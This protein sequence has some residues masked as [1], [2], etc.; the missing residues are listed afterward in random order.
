[1]TR[2]RLDHVGITVPDLDAATGFFVRCFGATEL[3]RLPDSGENGAARRLGVTE[4]SSFALVMLEVGGNRLELLAWRPQ[5][6]GAIPAA[7]DP[8]GAHV[9]I[10]VEDLD[11]TLRVLAGEPGVHNVGAPLRFEGGPTPGLTNAFVRAPWGT[12][13]ELMSESW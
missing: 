1:M 13:L 11:A 8:G 2:P 7:N 6:G 4:P 3:F 10:A 5:I 12:L 9:A